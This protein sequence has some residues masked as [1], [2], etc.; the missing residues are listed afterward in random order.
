VRNDTGQAPVV[1][2]ETASPAAGREPDATVVIITLGRESLYRLIPEICAQE[3]GFD[4]EILLIANGPV[5]EGRL[6]PG[7]VRMV[8]E[9]PGRG[10]SYYRN[11]GIAESRGRIVAY[12][13]DDVL[14]VDTSWLGRLVG[15]IIRG[16]EEATTGGARISLGQGYLADLIS[17]L[18]F[19]GGGALGW[20]NVWPVDRD[21]HTPKMCTCN[22]A[23]TRELLQKAGGF[24]ESV[25]YGGEDVYISEKMLEK[26]GYIGFVR[27]AHVMH[28][29]RTGFKDFIKWQ[30]RRGRTIRELKDVELVKSRQLY[31]RL[32]RTGIILRGAWATPRF[33]PLLGLLLLEQACLTYGYLAEYLERRRS[34]A[35]RI[36]VYHQ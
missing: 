10:Y 34:G 6:P 30:A 7:K 35:S 36:R 16:E 27:D 20:E 18:G 21:G 5:E 9:D 28:E 8:R 26:G 29:A 32:R 24:D 25:V 19:P 33:F 23:A 17:L 4:F 22:C 14:P 12:V 3:A 31:G 2:E 1:V 15:P 13:D 11:R